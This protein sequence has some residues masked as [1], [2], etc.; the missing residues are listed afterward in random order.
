MSPTPQRPPTPPGVPTGLVVMGVS[1]AGKTTVARLLSDRLG[2]AFA[3]ADDFHP[4][5]NIEKM[6][7][8][9]P[10]TDADRG[11]WLRAIA[12]WLAARADAGENAIVTCSALKRAYRD[13]L[14]DAGPR[15]RFVHLHGDHDTLARRIGGR[16]GHFMPP[17]LLDSQLADLEPLG[18]EEDGVVVDIGATPEEVAEEALRRLGRSGA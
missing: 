17:A 13:V 7:A 12:A 14:R 4:R 10:L 16:S 15:V 2:W 18:P 1:G 11:P 9:T 3:E 6:R 8:G 5:T